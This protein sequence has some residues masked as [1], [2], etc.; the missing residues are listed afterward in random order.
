[1]K[2]ILFS[3]ILYLFASLNSGSIAQTLGFA[4]TKNQKK[5]KIPFELHNNLIVLSIVLNGALPLKFVLDTGVR[6]AILTDKDF[7]DLL[8]MVYTKKYVI[9]GVG[10]KQT[11]N[12]YI[13]NNVSFSLPGVEGKG[14]ALLVLEDDLLELKNYLGTDVHGI[15]G[16]ELFSRFVVKINYANK[17]I[18]LSEPE[19]MR[20]PKRYDHIPMTIEDTKPFIHATVVQDDGSEVRVK[21]MVDSGSSQSLFLDL[22]SNSCLELPEKNIHTYVGRGL[23]GPIEGY[24]GRLKAFQIG[25]YIMEEI[26]SNYPEKG[27]Y[28]SIKH[29]TVER[30]GSIGGEILSRFNVIFDFP[31]EKFY[32]KKNRFYKNDFTYNLSGLVIKAKG[33]GLTLYEISEVRKNSAGHE[34]GIMPGDIILSINNNS[35]KELELNEVIGLLNFKPNKKIHLQ[36]KRGDEILTKQFRL[37]NLI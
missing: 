29:S 16:Y 28:D 15:L 21:L 22:E 20:Y 10:N 14:H 35:Y 3:A 8:D 2:K 32:F 12:A 7:S 33:P 19:N 18:T 27:N 36:I 34:A 4:I 31:N 26:I 25:S 37:R 5:V 11:V 9:S 6:T 30:N 17:M 1:M 13:T 24:V 23:G